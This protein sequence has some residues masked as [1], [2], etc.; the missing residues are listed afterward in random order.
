MCLPGKFDIAGKFDCR[1]AGLAK[2]QQ[3]LKGGIAQTRRGIWTAAMVDQKADGIFFYKRENLQQLVLMELQLQ[4]HIQIS[5]P[6]EQRLS[7]KII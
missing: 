4:E 2:C 5:E 6:G 3:C 1:T 7:P